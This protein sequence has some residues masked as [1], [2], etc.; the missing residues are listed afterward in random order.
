MLP[1]ASKNVGC[2]KFKAARCAHV[3]TL[4]Y[5]LVSGLLGRGLHVRHRP[6]TAVGLE[7][8]HVPKLVRTSDIRATQAGGRR[9]HVLK[10]TWRARS[11][12]LGRSCCLQMSTLRSDP[13][14]GTRGP[15]IVRR[16]L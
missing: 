2:G 8:E 16:R 5:P 9:Q 14:R 12:S 11:R 15:S 13:P 7:P 3:L 6:T 1:S 4:T 10:R